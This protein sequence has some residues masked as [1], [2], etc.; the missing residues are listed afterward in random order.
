MLRHWPKLTRFL[1]VAGAPI[2]NN[3]VERALKIAIRNRKAAMFYRTE[4]S[5]YIGG[6]LTSLIYT[7]HLANKN[8]QNYLT[9]L[10]NHKTAVAST[11]ELFLPWNYQDTIAANNEAASTQVASLH[12]RDGP[13]AA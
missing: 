6:V 10:Q 3:L 7:C 2:D 8:P 13:V 12:Q 4:Y 5:A 11:P 9:A 1:T